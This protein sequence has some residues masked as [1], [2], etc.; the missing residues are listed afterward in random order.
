MRNLAS[1]NAAPVIRSGDGGAE[2][3]LLP[4]VVRW[5]LRLESIFLVA[6]GVT[7]GFVAVFV[8]AVRNWSFRHTASIASSASDEDRHSFLVPSDAETGR[9]EVGRHVQVGPGESL[10]I[11]KGAPQAAVLSRRTA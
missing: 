5:P 10:T 7:P 2:E 4:V 11:F 6:R 8:A 1:R 9:T 3:R